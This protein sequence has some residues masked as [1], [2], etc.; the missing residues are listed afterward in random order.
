VP[1]NGNANMVSRVRDE[2][3]TAGDVE[4]GQRVRQAKHADRDDLV[5]SLGERRSVP[6]RDGQHEAHVACHYALA[7]GDIAEGVR[8]KRGPLVGCTDL[9][10]A[11]EVA[12]QA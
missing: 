12:A 4:C 5:M 7:G 3:D 2:P 11:I 1:L 10:R 6:T 8:F 9:R